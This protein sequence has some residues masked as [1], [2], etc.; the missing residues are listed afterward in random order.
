MVD[1]MSNGSHNFW[2]RLKDNFRWNE[3]VGGEIKPPDIGLYTYKINR[4]SGGQMRVH[5]RIEPGDSGELF[6]DVHHQVE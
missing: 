6:V 4:H 3:K 1:N 2:D 5:L